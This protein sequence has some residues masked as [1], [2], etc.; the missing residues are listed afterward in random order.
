MA[1]RPPSNYVER[2]KGKKKDRLLDSEIDGAVDDIINGASMDTL[3]RLE[4]RFPGISVSPA[5]RRE[6]FMGMIHNLKMR[7]FGTSQIAKS[8]GIHEDTVYYYYRQ[9]SKSFETEMARF[10]VLEHIG[11]SIR[12]YREFQEQAAKL[13]W[14]KGV[15]PTPK[16][17]AINSAVNVED[18]INQL[19][20]DV[21]AFKAIHYTPN[22]A[23]TDIMDAEQ[24]A[25][26]FAQLAI[27]GNVDEANRILDMI[28]HPVGTHS[29]SEKDVRLIT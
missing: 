22:L 24:Q 23:S 11:R 13:V 3:E 28:E 14:D 18:R 20:K 17:M 9:I 16:I 2:K 5:I 15:K 8:L 7:G 1:K 10:S 29:F 6:A 12:N 4:T 21:G 19:L 26:S 25:L 27:D